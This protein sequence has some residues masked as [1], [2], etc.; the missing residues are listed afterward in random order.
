MPRKRRWREG[1]HHQPTDQPLTPA[2]TGS[3]PQLVSPRGIAKDLLR[4]GSIF[5]F[6]L[7]LLGLGVWANQQ[8]TLLH[9][10]SAQLYLFLG[11]DSGQ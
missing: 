2:K 3:D 4:V 10:W 9:D 7:V 1:S 11:F 6:L 8:T 5:V